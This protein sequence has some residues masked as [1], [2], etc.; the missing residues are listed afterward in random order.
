MHRAALT[1]TQLCAVAQRSKGLPAHCEPSPLAA[2]RLLQDEGQNCSAIFEQ[3]CRH[4][5]HK[6]AGLLSAAT[7]ACTSPC[8]RPGRRSLLQRHHRQQRPAPAGSLCRPPSSPMQ[9]QRHQ[10]SSARWVSPA[11]IISASRCDQCLAA[12]WQHAM[13]SQAMCMQGPS[14]HL[15]PFLQQAAAA[16]LPGAPPPQAQGP[17]MESYQI[18]PYK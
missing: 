12:I 11:G 3:R 13:L 9:G 7:S 8:R 15:N 1:G 10:P 17:V 5:A 6:H 4:V 2:G 18:S 14:S 16:P